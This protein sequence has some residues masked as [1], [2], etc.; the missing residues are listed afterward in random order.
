MN[1]SR[2]LTFEPPYGKCPKTVA[3]KI[4]FPEH[5][6]KTVLIFVVCIMVANAGVARRVARP[7]NGDG[8]GPPRNDAGVGPPIDKEDGIILRKPAESRTGSNN[9]YYYYYKDRTGSNSDYY[10]YY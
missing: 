5:K 9:G 7:R 3:I 4:P 1:S 8:V 6:M 10:Y 2:T